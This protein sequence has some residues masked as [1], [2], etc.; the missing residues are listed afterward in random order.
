MGAQQLAVHEVV[1]VNTAAASENKIHD[2]SIAR[3]LGYHEAVVPGATIYG[4]M[5]HIPVARWGHAWLQCGE[6]ECRFRRP[7]Y[8]GASVRMTA[9]E[10][11]NRLALSVENAGIQCAT[12]YASCVTIDRPPVESTRYQRVCLRTSG[13]WQVRQALRWEHAWGLHL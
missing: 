8:D 9:I 11:N 3:K 7:V 4:Y 10:E 2:A 12:G 6:A 13:Q 1:A 5:A